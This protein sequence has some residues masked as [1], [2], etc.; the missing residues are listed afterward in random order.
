MDQN[1]CYPKLF[2]RIGM[3][4]EHQDFGEKNFAESNTFL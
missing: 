2:D 1:I 4:P 3:D